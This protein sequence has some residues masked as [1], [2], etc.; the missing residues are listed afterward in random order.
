MSTFNAPLPSQVEL[1]CLTQRAP[2][3]LQGIL[4]KDPNDED[5]LVFL[6][7]NSIPI[8]VEGFRAI[9]N[10]KDE[11]QPILTLKIAEHNET[12]LKLELTTISPKEQRLFPRLFGIIPLSFKIM[13]SSEEYPDWMSNTSSIDSSWETP[14]PLM[15]FSVNGVSFISSVEIAKNSILLIELRFKENIRCTARVVR[16][17]KEE[18]QFEIGVYFEE[19]PQEAIDHLTEMTLQLQRSLL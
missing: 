8:N 19:I 13:P 17:I 10:F 5:Q 1:L 14:E 2:L 9:V 6:S 12:Q 18:S 11:M 15:N 7:D 16:C 4:S 3:L